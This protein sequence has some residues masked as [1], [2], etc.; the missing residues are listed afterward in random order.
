MKLSVR[1]KLLPTLEQAS[2]LGSTLRALNV[3][4]N[5]VS[6][7]AY[8][9][10]VP[11]EYELRRHTY[12]ELK[13]R[14]LGAQ[15]AQLTIRK[16]RDAYTAL[17]G[18]IT[19]GN[20]GRP[21]SVRR[22]KAEAKPVNFRPDAAHPYDDRNLSWNLDV[23]TVSIWTTA[24]RIKHVRFACSAGALKMLQEHRRGESDLIECDGAFYLAAV[25]DVAEPEP[26]EPDGFI[27][28][29]LGIANVA[30]ASTG[31]RAAGRGL[32]RYRRRQLALRA[33]LQKKGT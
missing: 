16:V 30:T 22:V 6:K 20:L 12:A 11:R 7:V 19:A 24:G 2:A 26:Y 1:V 28:V 5:R 31:Y 9:R 29:D 10:G 18:N 4:A 21:G 25:C 14:G 13:E 8:E 15:A 3:A 33:K 27:G 17:K 32:D 23:Q